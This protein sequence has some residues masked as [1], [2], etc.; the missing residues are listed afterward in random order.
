MWWTVASS[1]GSPARLLTTWWTVTRRVHRAPLAGPV[2][3]HCVSPAHVATLPPVGPLDVR[4]ERRKDRID[5]AGVE[6]LVKNLEERL[7]RGIG[8]SH[9]RSVSC[10]HLRTPL[11][12]R[13]SCR[14][15]DSVRPPGA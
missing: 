8:L 5:V 14:C 7:R 12:G 1:R 2:V 6:T 9:R 3:A 13:R 10:V 15:G 4:R 11:G